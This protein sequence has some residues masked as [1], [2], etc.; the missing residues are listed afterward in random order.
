MKQVAGIYLP[1]AEA[2]MTAYLEQSGG[3]YQSK[4]LNRALQFVTNWSLAVD[5]GAHVGLWSKIL[6]QKFDRVV[7][8]EPMPPLRACLEKNVVSEKIQ[9]VP[10]A[11]GNSHGSVCF[12]Y[13]EAHTGATHIDIKKKGLIPLGKLDDFQLDNIGFIKIDTEGFELLV[14]EGARETIMR[15]NPVIIVED[16][17]HGVRHYGQKPYAVI[18]FLE[19]C[20]ACIMDRVVDDF[21]MG[22]PNI[23]GKVQ[24]LAA[25]NVDQQMQE[26][27]A[28]H[29]AGDIPGAKLAYRK[30]AREYP[31][32]AEADNMLAI[33]ELQAGNKQAALEHAMA[34]VEKTPKEARFQNTMATCLW[35]NGLAEDAIQV[36]Q[37]AVQLNPDLFEAYLNL[38]EIYEASQQPKL[39]F[40][41]FQQA[42]RIKPN[43]PQVLVKLGRIHANH[44]SP[45]QASTL[46]RQAL[47][48]NP[49]MESAKKGLAAVGG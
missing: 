23:P 18:E 30:I 36:L 37:R 31:S 17:Q 46:F 9:V 34:S 44:G 29:N 28:R 5:I 8:F 45:A 7:A 12:D 49:A 16:K 48:I 14:L 35:M 38:G 13:D 33:V 27:V 21:V 19:S 40:E 10:M 43:S 47:A 4:Q 39:A 42:L 2:N 32:F 15:C 26:A 22:W 20:G 41:N 11:L 25:R 24:K 6:V 3:V 1:D